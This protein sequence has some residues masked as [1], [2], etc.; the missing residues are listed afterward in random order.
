MKKTLFATL[1]VSL[2]AVLFPSLAS[3]ALVEFRVLIDDDNSTSTSTSV[4][5]IGSAGRSSWPGRRGFEPA[6]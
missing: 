6:E 4:S 3:A 5:A 1:F 2:C